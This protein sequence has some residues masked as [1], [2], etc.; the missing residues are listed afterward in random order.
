VQEI[1][2]LITGAVPPDAGEEVS[3]NSAM[4]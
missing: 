4:V 2:G 1:V 3:D